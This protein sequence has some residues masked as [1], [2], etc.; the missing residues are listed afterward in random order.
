MTFENIFALKGNIVFAPSYNKLE[1]KENSYLICE[2][3]LIKSI[4]ATKPENMHIR[5][6]GNDII[7]PGM[8]DLHL[9]APQYTYRATG[10]D[11]ELLDWLQKTAF[12]EEVRYADTDYAKKAYSIFTEDLI[13]S[14]TTRA[15]IF[16]TVHKEATLVLMD[17]LEES[18]LITMVGKVNMDRLCPDTIREDTVD[19][20][21]DT[22]EWVERSAHFKNTYPI[23]TPR[24]LPSCTNELLKELG[25]IRAKYSLPVQSHLSENL[26]EIDL[27]KELAPYSSFYGDAYDHFGLFGG[28]HKNVM[29]HCVYSCDAELELIKKNDVFIAHCPQSNINVSSGIAPVRKYIDLDLNIGLGTDISGGFSLS[30]FRAVSDAIQVSKLRWRIIDQ[31]LKALNFNEAFYMATKGGGRFFG[32]VGSFEEG[33]DADILVLNDDHIKSAR[34]FNIS[35]RLER[36]IYLSGNEAI[37]SKYVKGRK[38]F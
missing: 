29:A 17:M 25:K 3:G 23:I 20:F 24:F 13:K 2:N 33:Y 21:K 10:M 8:T 35:E 28:G 4:T 34:P 12:P 6:M 26:S 38:I 15:V 14:P 11:L 30:M 32:N 22:I 7:I 5:D 27:V 31:S 36:I 9:H 37:V 1:I 16:A 19:S 18:G